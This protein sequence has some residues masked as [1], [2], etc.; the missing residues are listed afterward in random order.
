[1]HQ[2]IW[3]EAISAYTAWTRSNISYCCEY[4]DLAYQAEDTLFK[5]IRKVHNVSQAKYT[6]D[7][8]FYAIKVKAE[9]CQICN[10]YTTKIRQHL[11]ETHHKM[12][13][14]VYF[15]RFVFREV[16][17]LEYG[18]GHPDAEGRHQVIGEEEIESTP[19]YIEPAGKGIKPRQ[20]DADSI[21]RLI[22]PTQRNVEPLG[23]GIEPAQKYSEPFEIRQ[24]RVKSTPKGVKTKREKKNIHLESQNFYNQDQTVAVDLANGYEAN[25]DKKPFSCDFCE[26]TFLT[27]SAST[28]HQ[29]SHTQNRKQHSCEYC[30]KC[31]SRKD[32]LAIHLRTHTGER[33]FTCDFCGKAFSDRTNYK[34]HER[35][36]TGEMPYRCQSC[37]KGFNR[38]THLQLHKKVHMH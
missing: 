7:N 8:P 19:R 25:D 29:L 11:Q 37:G 33:P 34:R 4:C 26:K 13:P 12:A 38:K 6:K 32:H 9:C 36:H 17:E 28:N 21:W 14:E 30:G 20:V 24:I 27:Y 10:S 15:M 18:G 35:A 3:E 5:H 1:M 23:K 31:F 16:T 2:V 22:E